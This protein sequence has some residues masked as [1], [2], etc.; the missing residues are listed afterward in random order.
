MTTVD[1]IFNRYASQL[2]QLSALIDDPQKL[3]QDLWGSQTPISIDRKCR[4]QFNA[5]LNLGPRTSF[6]CS[7]CRNLSRLTNLN[8]RLNNFVIRCGEM[9][10][11]ELTITRQTVVQ[12]KIEFDSTP[13]SRALTLLNKVNNLRTCCPD[14]TRSIKYLK[15]DD[16]TCR[17]LV[18][19][20]YD[21][22]ATELALPS[23]DLKAT[24]I[25]GDVGYL[26]SET[27]YTLPEL[28]TNLQT[29]SNKLS[30]APLDADSIKL[31]LFQ[32]IILFHRFKACQYTLGNANFNSIKLKDQPIKYKLTSSELDFDFG[33]VLE[34]G[35]GSSITNK[36]GLRIYSCSTYNQQ[37]LNRLAFNPEIKIVNHVQSNCHGCAMSLIPTYVLDNQTGSLYLNMRH[38]GLPLFNGSFDL[39]SL[40][41]SLMCY[42]PW[43][44]G[45][46]SQD[47]LYD[48]WQSCWL[49]DQ[50]DIVN[51][52]AK[53]YHDQVRPNTEQI[54]ADL[55]GLNLKCGLVD[56][57]MAKLEQYLA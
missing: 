24:F 47:K 54:I 31:I 5:S 20:I 46:R 8:D 49:N 42:R 3:S 26:I 30:D 16:Y 19:L 6:A 40:L 29:E 23:L 15:T 32:L 55:E 53:E 35:S 21:S 4:C 43:Y 38:S 37:E 28:I 2:T 52:R 41:Y 45:I 50:V 39:Y 33:L 17:L 57:L 36:N 9:K 12:P 22:M 56:V 27:K 14:L 10:G 44:L 18:N 11:I 34:P 7:N 1:A 48:F 25:C 51:Q 13:N